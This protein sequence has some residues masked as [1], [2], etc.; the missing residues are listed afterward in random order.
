M[1]PVVV[2]APG[3]VYDP[4]VVTRNRVDQSNLYLNCPCFAC[5]RRVVRRYPVVVSSDGPVIVIEPDEEDI[6]FSVPRR[7]LN[8]LKFLGVVIR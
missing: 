8:F 4:G 2:G 3:F 7:F 6:D 1:P 5:E